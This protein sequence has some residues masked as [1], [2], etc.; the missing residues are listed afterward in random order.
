MTNNIS[1][2]V[3]GQFMDAAGILGNLPFTSMQALEI[4][5]DKHP[6]FK[7]F[8]IFSNVSFAWRGEYLLANNNQPIK[9]EPRIKPDSNNGQEL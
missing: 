9:G 1:Y 6:V 3:V 2:S 5:K 8:R 7:P 4:W